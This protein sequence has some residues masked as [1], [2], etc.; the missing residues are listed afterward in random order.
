MVNKIEKAGKLRRIVAGIA[1]V[2]GVMT[3]K[4]GGSVLF[5]AEEA[6]VAAGNVVDF[7][8]WFNFL[9]GFV[10]ITTGLMLWLNRSAALVLAGL[11]ALATALVFVSLGIHIMAG[12]SYEPRTLAAMTLRL[13]VW[14]SIFLYARKL[15]GLAPTPGY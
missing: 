9:A 4:A 3:I 5:G 13:A 1:I 10:Y 14:L 2:F 11:L 12:G 8:L 15:F 6:R 7:V